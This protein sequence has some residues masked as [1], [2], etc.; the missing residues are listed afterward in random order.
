MNKDHQKLNNLKGTHL[1]IA[2][3]EKFQE[4]KIHV[5][6]RIVMKQFFMLIWI[7]L[8]VNFPAFFSQFRNHFLDFLVRYNV[9]D[10]W[11][12]AFARLFQSQL[13]SRD[14]KRKVWLQYEFIRH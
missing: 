4:Q 12:G 13:L 10:R 11:L 8:K 7:S 5:S 3:S 6:T 1:S 9:L 14:A 2:V